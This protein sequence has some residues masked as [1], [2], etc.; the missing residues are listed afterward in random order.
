MWAIAPAA[1]R[2]R[3][4][5]EHTL[6]ARRWKGCVCDARHRRGRMMRRTRVCAVA[7]R[8]RPPLLEPR[9]RSAVRL[10]C[11]VGS[12]RRAR[13]WVGLSHG[14][15]PAG[16]A[17]GAALGPLGRRG[18]VAIWGRGL[19]PSFLLGG[20]SRRVTRGNKPREYAGLVVTL[21]GKKGGGGAHTTT[22]D[23]PA[24]PP[25]P[26]NPTARRPNPGCK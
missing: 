18:R 12:R 4:C 24:R 8:W 23:E 20:G 16:A 9:W 7:H 11:T 1:K 15:H 14:P 17:S 26:E 3:F 25:T 21:R 2:K 5:W 19:A 22:H 10:I 13:R 6:T